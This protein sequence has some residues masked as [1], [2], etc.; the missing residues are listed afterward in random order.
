MSSDKNP[1]NSLV[2]FLKQNT[3]FIILLI[4]LLGIS[5]SVSE[6]VEGIREISKSFFMHFTYLSIHNTI[7]DASVTK[8]AESAARFVQVI[9]SVSSVWLF[10]CT[11][12]SQF[13][14]QMHWGHSDVVSKYSNKESLYALI[15]SSSFLILE[16][17]SIAISVFFVF[18]I[19]FFAHLVYLIWF[20]YKVLD[21]C[22]SNTKVRK[23]IE[24]Y[25]QNQMVKVNLCQL[26]PHIISCNNPNIQV[27]LGGLRNIILSLSQEA[28]TITLSGYMDVPI[29][30]KSLINEVKNPRLFFNIGQEIA[31]SI[32]ISSSKFSWK[33]E[34]L[35][36]IYSYAFCFRAKLTQVTSITVAA[37]DEDADTKKLCYCTGHIVG[38]ALAYV[39]NEISSEAFVHYINQCMNN[40]KNDSNNHLFTLCVKIALCTVF[41]K[42]TLIRINDSSI[43]RLSSCISL[44]SNEISGLELI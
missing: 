29:L 23:L 18:Y 15:V 36:E 14:H 33:Y 16:V 10:F 26:C 35:N 6:C 43:Y 13:S 42:L 28:G 38:I 31:Q 8:H 19:I 3:L 34:Y 27:V 12:L 9:I 41:R 24:Q 44:S 7:S 11:I 5:G 25:Y 30:I 22:S 4:V 2:S 20:S 32:V 17:L 21:F 1:F 39:A 37:A 40:M